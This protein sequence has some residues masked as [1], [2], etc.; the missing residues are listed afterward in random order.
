MPLPPE[1][2]GAGNEPVVVWDLPP[3]EDVVNVESLPLSGT[4]DAVIEST[5]PAGALDVAGGAAAAMPEEQITRRLIWSRPSAHRQTPVPSGDDV[6]TR[7]DKPRRRSAASVGPAPAPAAGA[8]AG[9][10]RV[11]EEWT[12]TEKLETISE[13]PPEALIVDAGPPPAVPTRTV[14]ILT[15][16]SDNEE[17]PEH[18]GGDLDDSPAPGL[19]SSRPIAGDDEARVI[20][21]LTPSG[22]TPAEDMRMHSSDGGSGPGDQYQQQQQHHHSSAF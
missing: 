12:Y 21:V 8:T 3:F 1:D 7:L 9:E 6:T 15:T 5:E 4:V 18:S 16:L 2:T 13:P 19:G 10:A 20:S 14:P 22:S 17:E 11:V